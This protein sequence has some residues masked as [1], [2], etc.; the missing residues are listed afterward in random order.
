MVKKG[1]GLLG[2]A[3]VF[4]VSPQGRRLIEQAKEFAQRPENREKAKA[5]LE[6]AR[7]RRKGGTSGP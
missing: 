6:Q 3:A 1:K 5:M 7:N 4:A 2:A